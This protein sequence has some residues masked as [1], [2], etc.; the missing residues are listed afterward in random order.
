[1]TIFVLATNIGFVNF[2]FIIHFAIIFT[3]KT[4]ANTL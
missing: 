3:A 1:M 2:N 4:F